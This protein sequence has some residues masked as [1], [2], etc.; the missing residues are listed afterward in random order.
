MKY[1]L[2]EI[3]IFTLDDDA[4]IPRGRNSGMCFYGGGGKSKPKTPPV[5][6]PP[7][8]I[9]VPTVDEAANS[10]EAADKMRRRRGAAANILT[11]QSG[12]GDLAAPKTMTGAKLLGQ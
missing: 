10:S 12:G 1:A 8:P 2:D 7:K 3:G 11:Q 9:P 5:P 6:E 4:F